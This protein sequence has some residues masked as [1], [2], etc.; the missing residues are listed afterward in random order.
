MNW[1]GLDVFDHS[2]TRTNAW[3]KEF[4][5]E[6]NSTDRR[7]AYHALCGVLHTV[8]DQMDTEAAVRFG[9]QLPLLIRGSYFEGWIPSVNAA[10][11]STS[12]EIIAKAVF[13][14]LRRKADEG[15]I[16]SVEDILPKDLQQLWLHTLR[17]A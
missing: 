1:T 3:L 16:E 4:M 2:I 6:L 11:K 9:N 7:E 13:R 12:D 15:E 14:L 10:P 5:Q 17:A 8:R